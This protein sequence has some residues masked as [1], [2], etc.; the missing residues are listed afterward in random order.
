[1]SENAFVIP[2]VSRSEV[3]RLLDE[4]AV[5]GHGGWSTG[6]RL[7]IW[8]MDEA[9]GLYQDWEPE[10]I[11]NLEQAVGRRPE[12]AVQINYRLSRRA[13]LAALAV[14]LL[15]NGGVAVDDFCSHVWTA[16]EIET[17]TVIS[18]GRFGEG[19]VR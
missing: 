4:L 6:T 5:A 19:P 7:F 14:V 3:V 16:A 8:L 17:D 1:M 9:S 18:G 10:D 11:A 13:D 2:A 15:K 12:W